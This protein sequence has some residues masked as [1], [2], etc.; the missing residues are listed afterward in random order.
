VE[1]S[2]GKLRAFP[3]KV[4][5]ISSWQDDRKDLKSFIQST[6]NIVLIGFN[7]LGYDDSILAY[8]LELTHS[9]ISICLS[10]VYQLSKEIVG[11]RRGDMLPEKVKRYRYAKKSWA[12]LDMMHIRPS[13]RD[14]VSLKQ[15]SINLKWHRVQ[16]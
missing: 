4:F 6:K 8:L 15:M 14:F 10:L 13:S 1:I 16:D 3:K 9:P 11:T 2:E 5:E 12:S 7:S